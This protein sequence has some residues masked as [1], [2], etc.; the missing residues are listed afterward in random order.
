MASA[1]RDLESLLESLQARVAELEKRANVSTP[2]GAAGGAGAG[3]GA[4]ASAASAKKAPSLDVDPVASTLEWD[5][6]TE[7]YAPVIAAAATDIGDDVA[8]LVRCATRHGRV[9]AHVRV[10]RRPNLR[11]IVPLAFRSP[12]RRALSPATSSP[13][14]AASCTSRPSARSRRMR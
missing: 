14:P 10:V 13:P 3:A 12:P 8:L 11:Q 2:S 5:A 4:V 7:K 6:L 1:L 9:A